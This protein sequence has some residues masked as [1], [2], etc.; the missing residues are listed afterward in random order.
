MMRL[1]KDERNEPL[2]WIS[3]KLGLGLELF[4]KKKKVRNCAQWA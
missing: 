1:E 2:E 4:E 3:C